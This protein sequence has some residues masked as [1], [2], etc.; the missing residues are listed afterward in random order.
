MENGTDHTDI[1]NIWFKRDGQVIRNPQR[2]ETENIEALPLLDKS[3]YEGEVPLHLTYLALSQWGCPF[4]CSYCAVTTLAENSKSLGCKPW[5]MMSV[6]K[7]IAELK[8][9]HERYR[10]DSVFFMTNTFTADKKWVMEWAG[11]YPEALGLPYKIATHPTKID[12]EV[13]KALKASGCYTVQL[14]V[15]SYSEEVRSKIYN[16]RESNEQVRNATKAM[17]DA[18]LRYTIDYILG[19]PL[20]SEQEYREAAEFFITLKKCIRITPFIIAFFPRTPLVEIAR[21]HGMINEREIERLEQGLDPNFVTSGSLSDPATIRRLNAWRLF[22][23]LIPILPT[24][25]NKRIL[26]REWFRYFEYL[27]TGIIVLF[28][29]VAISFLVKD[30]VALG[31]LRTYAWN[32]RKVATRKLKR[33]W[34]GISG[35]GAGVP[36][37]RG[38]GN[39]RRFEA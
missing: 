3:V 36:G 39:G 30:Y 19:G 23:R 17:D 18:G 16:R 37:M 26:E 32:V 25:L 4:A 12:L 20:Q 22:F 6:D 5:R 29:D 31:Y 7:V 35:K 24:R 27:P 10:F 28:M 13:A 21:E 33:W 14:G 11:K 15:E 8:H 9:Y 34:G 38:T 2:E 1:R